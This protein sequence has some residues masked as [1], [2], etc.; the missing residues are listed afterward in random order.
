[1]YD[2]I[3]K[4]FPNFRT[5]PDSKSKSIFLTSQENTNITKILAL[6]IHRYSNG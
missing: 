1:M 6:H 5:I 4:I 2:K 3:E